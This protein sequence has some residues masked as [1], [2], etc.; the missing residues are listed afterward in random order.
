MSNINVQVVGAHK[1]ARTLRTPGNLVI[2][3]TNGYTQFT[4]KQLTDYE[5]VVLD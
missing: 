2:R 4:I 3:Q 5:L 1:S